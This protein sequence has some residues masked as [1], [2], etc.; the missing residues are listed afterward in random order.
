MVEMIKEKWH[1]FDRDVNGS[2]PH[3]LNPK[4]KAWL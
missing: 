3:V 1:G 4:G 2:Y